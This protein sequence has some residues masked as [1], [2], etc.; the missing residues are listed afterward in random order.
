MGS[1][2]LIKINDPNT[3]QHLRFVNTCAELLALEYPELMFLLYPMCFSDLIE[4][5]FWFKYKYQNKP[6]LANY[7]PSLEFCIQQIRESMQ[8]HNEE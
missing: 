1:L 8:Q 6:L 3:F 4:I 2:G 7:L 5:L